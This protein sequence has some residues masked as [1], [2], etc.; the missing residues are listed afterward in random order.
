MNL[1]EPYGDWW[2]CLNPREST[3]LS[4]LVVSYFANNE[5]IAQSAYT[6]IS[7]VSGLAP[8]TIV[9]GF[10]IVHYGLTEGVILDDEGLPVPVF[11]FDAEFWALFYAFSLSEAFACTDP[12]EAFDFWT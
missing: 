11:F 10:F 4:M 7:F 3:A 6:V 12:C 5:Y 9:N 8:L 2:C 1:S